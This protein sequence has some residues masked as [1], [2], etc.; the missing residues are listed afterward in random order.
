MP[1]DVANIPDDIS[2]LRKSSSDDFLIFYSDV[3]VN[4]KMWCPDCVRV[5]KIVKDVFEP[6]GA[7]TGSIVYV[8]LKHEW[9]TPLNPFRKEYQITSVPTIVKLKEVR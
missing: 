9:K 1:L 4:G 5:D 6:S 8:G 2:L 3:E 7:P